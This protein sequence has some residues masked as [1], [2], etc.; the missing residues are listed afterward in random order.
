MKTKKEITEIVN[1]L[2]TI[3]K[4]INNDDLLN[5]LRERKNILKNRLASKT[6][7]SVKKTKK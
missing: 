2:T 3:E 5:E 6:K 4:N 7:K 1:T